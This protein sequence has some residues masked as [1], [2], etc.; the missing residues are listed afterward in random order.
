MPVMTERRPI[1]P[2]GLWTVEQTADYLRISRGAA[3]NLASRAESEGGLPTVRLGRS[4]RVRA[5]R[6]DA[7]LD[8][9]A[10]R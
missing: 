8:A 10:A 1:E 4:V 9:R 6:L 2:V 5:D 3:Y 7:W